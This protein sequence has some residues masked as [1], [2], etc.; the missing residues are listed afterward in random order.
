MFIEAESHLPNLTFIVWR[1]WKLTGIPP[2]QLPP[3]VLLYVDLPFRNRASE[4][5]S[6]IDKPSSCSFSS[7]G[8]GTTYA[9]CKETKLTLVGLTDRFSSSTVTGPDL[10]S[11]FLPL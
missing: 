1:A 5:S 4:R 8:D 6:A 11:F 2:A 3:I 10:H 9:L 7:T